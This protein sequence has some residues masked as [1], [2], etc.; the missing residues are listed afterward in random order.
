MPDAQP[1]RAQGARG[2]GTRGG[3]PRGGDAV[4]LPELLFH[5]RPAGLYRAAV[6]VLRGT[7]LVR[8]IPPTHGLSL[9]CTGPGQG[10]QRDYRFTSTAGQASSAQKPGMDKA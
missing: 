1:R 7:W 6:V 2:E 3:P 10:E 8:W 4:F 9:L 5:V